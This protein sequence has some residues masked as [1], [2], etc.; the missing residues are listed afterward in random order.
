MAKEVAIFALV[1]AGATL[2]AVATVSNSTPNSMR[3][4]ATVDSYTPAQEAVARQAATQAGFTP[5]PV[6]FAQDGNFF[7]N[8]SKDGRSY[9][10]TVTPN[11]Q[12]YAST[13][14]KTSLM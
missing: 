1:M 7:F 8:A 12:V 5:S 9:A 13:S 10:L 2:P 4:V 14:T 11:G 3:Q 6:L